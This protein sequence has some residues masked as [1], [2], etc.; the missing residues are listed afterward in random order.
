MC[1]SCQLQKSPPL[2]LAAQVAIAVDLD[3]VAMQLFF[4]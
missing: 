4:T 3:R 1:I 2:V